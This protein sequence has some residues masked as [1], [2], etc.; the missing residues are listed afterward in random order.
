MRQAKRT[1]FVL[2]VLVLIGTPAYYF[3]V[4]PS[5]EIRHRQRAFATVAT[6][7]EKSAVIDLLGTPSSTGTPLTETVFWADQIRENIDPSTAVES[8][9]YRTG[10]FFLPVTFEFTFDPNGVVIGKHRYD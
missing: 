5:G 2:A 7:M 4:R 10:T 6:G 8:I 9:R 3:V 1:L